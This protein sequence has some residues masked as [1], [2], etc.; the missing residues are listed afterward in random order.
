MKKMK[1]LAVA[2]LVLAACDGAA[3]K[4][5]K[6][7]LKCGS[8]DVSVEVASPDTLKT[9]ING[10]KITMGREISASGARYVGKGAAVSAELW[11]KGQDWSLDIGGRFISCKSLKK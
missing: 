3:P 6:Y 10:E 1:T 8:Y 5:E 7:A 2:S 4:V 11:N 9:A